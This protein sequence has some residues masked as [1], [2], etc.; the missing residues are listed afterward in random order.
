[1]RAVGCT[2]G[3]ASACELR[4]YYAARIDA[5]GSILGYVAGE[6]HCVL[7]GCEGLVGGCTVVSVRAA[8]CD[9]LLGSFTASAQ[10]Q[11]SLHCVHD[12]GHH[13]R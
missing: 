1:M 6:G 12:E 5:C 10:T 7:A 4:T 3:D 11:S 9:G 2:A 13:A 8:G